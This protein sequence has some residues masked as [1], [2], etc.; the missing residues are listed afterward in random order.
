MP[1][2][3]NSIERI[4]HSP[5]RSEGA[6]YRWTKLLEEDPTPGGLVRFH[7]AHKLTLMALPE[8]LHRAAPARGQGGRAPLAGAERDLRPAVHG[9]VGA[10]GYKAQARQRRRCSI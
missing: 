2:R 4:S 7:T 3:E 8:A 6:Y 1:L 10:A 5:E 9:G